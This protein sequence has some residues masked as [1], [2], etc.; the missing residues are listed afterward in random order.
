MVSNQSDLF[1][2][3]VACESQI[4]DKGGIAPWI[5]DSGASAAFTSN[6]MDFS[7]LIL[8]ADKNRPPVQT[9]NGTAFITGH[10]TV[11]IKTK[12]KGIPTVTRLHP[13]FLLPN[14]KEQ[15]LSMGQLLQSKLR[16]YGEE[17]TLNLQDKI[18]CK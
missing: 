12:H 11:F 14:M 1:Q 17:N 16:L 13:V 15:L 6:T 18:H 3:C 7:E 4:K 2:Q 9:A 8:F 5:M 10:G